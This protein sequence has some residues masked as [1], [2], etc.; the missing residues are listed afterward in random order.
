MN[1]DQPERNPEL[2]KRAVKA[3]NECKLTGLPSGGNAISIKGLISWL[4][5]E[6]DAITIGPLGT[7][8]VQHISA[9]ETLQRLVNMLEPFQE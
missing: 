6:K 2:E 1:F 5:A 9:S 8:P 3:F 7:G 4:Q